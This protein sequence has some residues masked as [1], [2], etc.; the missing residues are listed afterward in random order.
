MPNSLALLSHATRHDP[1]LRARAVGVWTAAGGVAIATGPILGGVPVAALG[2]RSI[3]LVN[4]PV[5]ALGLLLTA[6]VTETV[7]SDDGRSFDVLGQ[8]LAALA[9][10]SLIGALIEMRPQGWSSNVVV[11]GLMVAV[12]AAAAFV[13]TERRTAR[14]MLPLGFFRIP[15]CSS[16][17]LYG[18]LAN[19]AYYGVVFVLSLYLQDVRG[20]SPGAAGLAYLP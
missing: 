15:N 13:A 9:L 8:V 17:V 10:A 2:W 3:F 7:R 5:C 4:V 20:F 14:P 12:C 19:L 6:R 11:A 1:G 18:I 16:A